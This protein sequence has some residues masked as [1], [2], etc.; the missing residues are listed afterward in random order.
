MGGGDL[1]HLVAQ[2]VGLAG[3][4]LR[5]AAQPGQRLVERAQLAPDGPH[6]AEIGAGEGVE[7]VALRRRA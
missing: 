1:L 5:V 6:P 3:P 2:D 7:D 4:L